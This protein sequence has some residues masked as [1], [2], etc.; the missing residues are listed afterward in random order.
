MRIREEYIKK[1]QDLEKLMENMA[2]G[3]K[4][5]D[6]RMMHM[7]IAIEMMLDELDAVFI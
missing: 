7:N 2:I 1:I 6:R 5:E 4:N 3:L